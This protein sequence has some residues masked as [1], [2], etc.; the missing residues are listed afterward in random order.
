MA[1]Q[2][3]RLM[4]C[5][6]ATDST[7]WFGCGDDSRREVGA[8]LTVASLRKASHTQS[9]GSPL[10][11]VI[12]VQSSYLPPPGPVALLEG[13]NLM[14]SRSWQRKL[15]LSSSVKGRVS[16]SPFCVLGSGWSLDQ[17]LLTSAA[18]A[19]P[20]MPLTSLPARC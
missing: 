3:G 16:V 10:N 17:F 1:L 11:S 7:N 13:E 20:L 5:P 2:T 4:T 15:C 6:M 19:I 18:G 12:H 9:H 8:T 14:A